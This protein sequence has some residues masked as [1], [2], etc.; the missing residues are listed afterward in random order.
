MYLSKAGTILN[1]KQERQEIASAKNLVDKN[2]AKNPGNIGEKTTM[3]HKVQ[4]KIRVV[5]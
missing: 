5:K 3:K 1:R 4:K 2:M